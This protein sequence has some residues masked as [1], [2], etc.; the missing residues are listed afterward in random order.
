MPSR[1]RL[2]RL[3]RH[4]ATPVAAGLVLGAAPAA[5]L[6]P[7]PVQLDFDGFAPG[8]PLTAV[9]VGDTPITLAVTPV[10]GTQACPPPTVVDDPSFGH[11]ALQV[12][13]DPLKPKLTVTFPAPL[14]PSWVGIRVSPASIP[15]ELA[16][17][18]P[19]GTYFGGNDQ[20]SGTPDPFRDGPWSPPVYVRGS[21]NIGSVELTPGRFVSTTTLIVRSI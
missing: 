5:A 2:G 9:T 7:S 6:A 4:T 11:R 14:A 20:S 12:S 13:C 15:V 1:L 10:T 3:A 16:E 19:S 8:T 17:Y 18:Y 21:G